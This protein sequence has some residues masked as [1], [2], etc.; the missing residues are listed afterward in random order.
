[1]S[2]V[3]ATTVGRGFGQT[4]RRDTWWVTPLAV[5]LGFS[6]FIVYATWA[7]FQGEHYDVP[8]DYRDRAIDLGATP[9]SSRELIR[10]PIDSGLRLR[11]AR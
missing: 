7:A 8:A 3:Q 11:K 6:S 2:H 4:E 1:M 5:F 9:V 10:R